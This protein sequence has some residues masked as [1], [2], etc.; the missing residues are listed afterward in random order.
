MEIDS[1][2]EDGEPEPDA[3]GLVIPGLFHGQSIEDAALAITDYVQTHWTNWIQDT[4][5]VVVRSPSMLILWSRR[6]YD[7]LILA[8]TQGCGD[9]EGL[10]CPRMLRLGD[11][12]GQ[13]ACSEARQ[14]PL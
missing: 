12:S 2:S 6:V 4:L 1:T 9:K 14:R 8:R 13:N 7:L 11:I 3:N 5:P 10:R